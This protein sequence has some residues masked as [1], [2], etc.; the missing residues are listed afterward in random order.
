M[1]QGPPCPILPLHCHVASHK[2]THRGRSRAWPL[3]LTLTS[4]M[5]HFPQRTGRRDWACVS[6][7]PGGQ[8]AG[9]PGGRADSRAGVGNSGEWGV[10]GRAREGTSP[11]HQ[12][13]LTPLFLHI[14]LCLVYF[15]PKLSLMVKKSPRRTRCRDLGQ[16]VLPASAERV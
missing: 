11:S 8:A 10:S 16:S 2:P 15:L 12:D 6:I 3:S 9:A 4:L 1:G 14:R 5:C 13:A 7:G